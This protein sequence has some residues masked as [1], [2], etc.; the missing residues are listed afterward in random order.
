VT[1]ASG[2]TVATW[3]GH[4]FRADELFDGWTDHVRRESYDVPPGMKAIG[5]WW[6]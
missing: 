4:R 5:V 6:D 2:D 3:L 1:S